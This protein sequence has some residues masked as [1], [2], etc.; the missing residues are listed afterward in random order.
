[1]RP[2]VEAVFRYTEQANTPLRKNTSMDMI[3]V[4]R[5][6]RNSNG[7]GDLVAVINNENGKAVNPGNGVTTNAAFARAVSRE[8][9]LA[10]RYRLVHINEQGLP[11]YVEIWQRLFGFELQGMDTVELGYDVHFAAYQREMAE[12]HI[13][14]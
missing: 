10:R 14:D 11:G 2:R 3:Y 6:D 5:A 12:V 7:D 13:V 4:F 1:M 8:K 9:D